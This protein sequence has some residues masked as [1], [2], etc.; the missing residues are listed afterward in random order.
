MDSRINEIKKA[1]WIAIIGNIILAG[2]KIAGGLISGSVAVLSDGIDS[3][4][5]IVTSVITLI[6][7]RIISK[8]PNAQYPYGYG[9]AETIA[10]KVLSFII[11]FVGV[12]LFYST[13]LR[14]I[15]GDTPETPAVIA[16]Y[17]TLIS[18]AGKLLLSYFLFKTGK[19]IQSSMIIANAKNMRND[20]FISLAVL[21]GLVFTFLLNLTILDLLT[22]LAV[23]IWIVKT[24]FG[25]F[26]ETSME[27]MDGNKNTHI[28]N[29]IFKAVETVK[30]ASNPHRTRVRKL[31]NM[32]VIDL[33][34]E[35]DKNLNVSEA[36]KI[37]QEVENSIKR[38]VE[39]VYDI[40]V[41]IEPEGNIE[42][43][44]KYGL[45]KDNIK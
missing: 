9:R 29:N 11:F 6:T 18:I 38:K 30:G 14:I 42:V 22:A 37:A 27:L 15:N 43:N 10:A 21:T 39:N 44:E 40:I 25:I 36:H 31:A 2:L 8:K 17:I 23:S 1:S 33:D 32:Y 4:T 41:H 19:K 3:A 26:M 28:Y 13:L 35:V 24:A 16:I 5:D 45:S 34:I 7:A 20:I 12:Q